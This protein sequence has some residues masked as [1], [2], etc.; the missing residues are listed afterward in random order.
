[1]RAGELRRQ[2]TLQSRGASID[3]WGQQSTGWGGDIVCYAQ[4]EPLAG[5]ELMAAQSMQAET[6]HTITIRYRTGVTPAMR[7]LYQGRVFNVLSVID[8]DMTHTSL[9]LLCSEGLNN[10]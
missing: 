1:M 7:A 6:T 9:Q 10:G 5:R 3:S 2:I 8:P 4:I